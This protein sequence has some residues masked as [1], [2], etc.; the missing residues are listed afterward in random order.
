MKDPR[1]EKLAD[2]LV[3]Y[4]TRVQRDENV[5]IYAIG[6]VSE[7]V[8]AVIRK[9]YEAGGNPYGTSVTANEKG[10]VSEASLNAAKHQARRTVTVARWLK[11]GQA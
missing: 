7:L 6:E 4:S 10:E 1:I 2:V 5:L 3:N 8:R 11:Q 9:V